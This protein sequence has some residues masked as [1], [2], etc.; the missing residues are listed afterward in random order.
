MVALAA[1]LK[2]CFE[3]F[4]L[5]QKAIDSNFI[6]GIKVTCRSKIAKIVLTGIQDGH[7]LENQY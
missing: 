7:H 2:I 1:K 3:L 6:G 4:L 5:N